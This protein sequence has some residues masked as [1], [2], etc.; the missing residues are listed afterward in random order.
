MDDELKRNYRARIDSE[1]YAGPFTEEELNRQSEIEKLLEDDMA[2]LIME[3]S[4][5]RKT[6]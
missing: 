4:K 5:K 6:N 2:E 3:Q 1:S